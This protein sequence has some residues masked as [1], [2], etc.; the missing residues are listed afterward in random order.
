MAS[1]KFLDYKGSKIFLMDF[2]YSEIE[3][4]LKAIDDATKI[5]AQQP[6]LSVLGLVDVS[7]SS[8]DRV[9][10]DALKLFSE[11]NK[12]FMKMTAIVGIEGV[13]AVILQ[14]IIKFTGRKNLV[15]KNSVQEAKD[16]LV[17]QV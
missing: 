3:D 10:A 17:T 9:L 4:V 2:S 5:I 1:N 7:K 11:H 16:W 12:P 15:T 13:K 14:A 6:P 8:F